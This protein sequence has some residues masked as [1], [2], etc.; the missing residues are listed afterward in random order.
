MLDFMRRNARSTGIKIA[1]GIIVLTFIFFM[2]GGSMIGGSPNAV[3]EVDDVEITM[4]EYQLALRRQENYFRQQ[5]GGQLN[6]Q[7]MKALD[8]PGMTL[9]QLVDSAALRAEAARL[10]LT[11]PDEAV[12]DTIRRS[13]Q[14]GG[15]G[16]SPTAYRETLSRQGLSPAVFE[17]TVRRDLL[18]AQVADIIRRGAH[19]TEEDAW[20]EYQRDNRKMTLSYIEIDAAHFLDR[21]LVK[22]EELAPWFE[23]RKEQYRRPETVRVKYIAYKVDDYAAKGGATEEE[24][25]QY[26][27]LNK[28]AQFTRPEQVAARHI[29]KK[30]PAGADEA[31]KK[32]A[33][34]AIDAIALRLAAGEDFATVAK[35]ES[36]DEGSAPTGGDLGWFGRGRM[37]P[38]FD[39]AAFELEKGKISGIVETNFGFHIIQVYDKREA[40]V[41][42]LEEVREEIVKTLGRQNAIDKVFEDSAA[43][44]AALDEGATLETIA[45]ERGLKIE[46][47]PLFDQDDI[48]PGIG[49]S[50]AFA[51]AALSLQE[52]GKHAPPVK[53]GENYYLIALAE[54]KESYLPEL[55]DVREQ[56]E[57]DYKQDKANELARK[58]ADEL[59]ESAKAGMTLQQLAEKDGL[60]VKKSEPFA[61][62]A[63]TYGTLGAVPGLGEVAFA[64]KEDGE[65]LPRTFAVG[66][67]AYVF[68]RDSVTEAER[69]EFD[70]VKDEQIE[71]LRAKREQEALDEFIRQLKEKAE[72]TYNVAALRPIL[73]E[74]TPIAQ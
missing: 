51:Q 11:V 71:E 55:A 49:P 43:D 60:E 64:T 69:S 30:V 45:Q 53:V 25:Q 2:G 19:A 40:G 5:F 15:G 22:D 7:M 70:T 4:N 3:A 16:F 67:K 1:L 39:A 47:T 58:R 66:P 13:F 57:A 10:D 48:I 74:N 37:V 73:G 46:E 52:V 33:R 35:A 29:L 26:Y 59:L 54:R 68:A 63:R 41:A 24:I 18:S 36:E 6:E 56:V 9:R 21:I 42:P 62:T 44:A 8:I 17:E 34:E 72:I 31:A 65:L 61:E 28:T 20:L 23:E 14:Q 27:D 32:A 12:R 38:P 50:P